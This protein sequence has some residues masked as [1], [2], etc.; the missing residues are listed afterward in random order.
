MDETLKQVGCPLHCSFYATGKEGFSRNVKRH[1]IVEQV[2]A[3]EEIF[4]HRVTNVVFMG[5]SEPMINLKSV[6]EAHQCLNKQSISVEP[7]GRFELS[8]APLETLHQVCMEV[9]S[10]L[11]QVKAVAEKMGIGFPEIGGQPKWSIQ[12]IPM[13]PR[14]RYEIANNYT[15]KV[16]SLGHDLIFRT[17][18]VQHV[19]SSKKPH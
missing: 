4:K 15:A 17:C 12:D 3:I 16:G 9:D 13:M 8:G 18:T 11:C 7:G 10:Q 6:L 5:M 14:R 19:C 2:L 1:E